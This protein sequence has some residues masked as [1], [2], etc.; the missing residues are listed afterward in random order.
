MAIS[1]HVAA[2]VMERYGDSLLLSEKS[3]IAATWRF[4]VLSSASIQMIC[5]SSPLSVA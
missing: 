3:K 5:R 2:G 4:R 1:R